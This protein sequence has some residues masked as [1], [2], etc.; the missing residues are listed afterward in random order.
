MELEPLDHRGEPGGVAF[1]LGGGARIGLCGGQFEQF[2]GIAQTAR[3]LLQVADDAFQVGPFPAQLLR[4][5][6]LVPD[7]GLFELARYLLKTLALVIVIK[8]TSSRSR[9]DPR[10]L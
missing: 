10:D 5:V 2:R 3:E 8:D 1:D 7:A 9:C 6:G 4:A